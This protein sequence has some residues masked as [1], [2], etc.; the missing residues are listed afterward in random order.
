VGAQ[1]SRLME[2]IHRYRLADRYEWIAQL[3]LLCQLGEVTEDFAEIQLHRLQPS[4]EEQ[5]RRF[6]G[7][8]PAPTYEELYPNAAPPLIIGELE[9]GEQAPIGVYLNGAVH[10]IFVGRTGAGKTVGLRRLILAVEKYNRT[11]D[12]PIILIVLDRKGHDFADLPGRLG[13]HWVHL[14][15]HHGMRLGLGGPQDVPANIWVNYLTTVFCARAGLRAAWTTLANVLRW[16]VAA[17]NPKPGE[18]LLWPDWQ[19]ILDV[20]RDLPEGAFSAKGEYVRSLEQVLEGVVQASGDLFS[21][22]SGFDVNDLVRQGKSAVISMPSISP[23]W[24]RQFIADLLI[25]QFL[26]RAIHLGETCDELRMLFVIDEADPDVS[27]VAEQAFPDQ[28][29]PISQVLRQ[30]RE[31]GIGVCLGLASLGPVARHVLNSAAYHFVFKL[32]HDVCRAEASQTLCLPPYAGTIIPALEPGECLV[33][34]PFWPHAM[35]SK[36]DFV[37][38]CR[39]ARPCYDSHPYVPATAPG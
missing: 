19:L 37:P 29:S 24:V 20:L 5:K 23:A 18:K 30:G 7:L 2:V 33:R 16:L 25:G 14:S 21:S 34:T 9:E 26:L 31:F 4:I 13:D 1:V 3:E 36:I 32:T 15:V 6:N 10:C 12:K 8:N 35:L 28:F 27:A 11:H 38:P 22:F 39:G 17:M